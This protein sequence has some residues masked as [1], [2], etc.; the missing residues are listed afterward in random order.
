MAIL[1]RLSGVKFSLG[2]ET[3]REGRSV[4]EDAAV[5]NRLRFA[6]TVFGVVFHHA[7]PGAGGLFEGLIAYAADTILPIRQADRWI[8]SRNIQNIDFANDFPE[9]LVNRVRPFPASNGPT[10]M[11]RLFQSPA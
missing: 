6:L 11:D 1:L 8:T 7:G 4:D 10:K 3:R 5:R 9:N 2:G